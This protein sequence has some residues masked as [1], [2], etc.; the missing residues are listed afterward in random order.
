MADLVFLAIAVSFFGVCVAY[1]RALDRMVRRS[2]PTSEP[3]P[4]PAPEQAQEVM[5]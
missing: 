5:P 3:R 1:V 2:E 4:E